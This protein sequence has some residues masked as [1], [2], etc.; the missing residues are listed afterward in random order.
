MTY[1]KSLRSKVHC[2]GNQRGWEN[3]TSTWRFLQVDPST[4]HDHLREVP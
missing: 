3:Q 4:A 1:L 2:P